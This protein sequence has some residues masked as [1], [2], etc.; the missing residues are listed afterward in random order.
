M[1]TKD[2]CG[3]VGGEPGMFMKIKVAIRSKPEYI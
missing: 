2:H 1:K 3:K